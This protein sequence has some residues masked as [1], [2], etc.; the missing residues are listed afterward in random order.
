VAKIHV[1]EGTSPE[2]GTYRVIVHAPTSA[3]NNAAGISWATAIKNSGRAFTR[4]TVGVGAGQI[5]SAEQAEVLNG[6][7][8][9]GEFQVGDEA[10]F[11][12]AQRNAYLDAMAD[13]FITELQAKWGL[14][15]RY[16]GA[17]RS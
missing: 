17:T 4:M 3:G 8:M 13:R 6:T 2:P 5:T 9:E 11:S 16:F 14:E 12:G 7:V 10:G 15:L 1:L